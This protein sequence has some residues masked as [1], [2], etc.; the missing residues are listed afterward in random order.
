MKKK[1]YE[2]PQS[3]TILFEYEDFVLDYGGG[4]PIGDGGEEE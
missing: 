4:N 1:L 3:E 2:E